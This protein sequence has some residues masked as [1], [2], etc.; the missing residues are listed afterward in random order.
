[1]SY[2][3]T[4]FIW[5]TLHMNIAC[6]SKNKNFSNLKAGNIW[7]LPLIK[8]KENMLNVFQHKMTTINFEMTKFLPFHK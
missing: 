3:F 1:M 4:I 2:E 7:K 6:N 8:T 5:K